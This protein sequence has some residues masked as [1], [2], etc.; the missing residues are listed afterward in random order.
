MAMLCTS[1]HFFVKCRTI[2]IHKALSMR[3]WPLLRNLHTSIQLRITP[4][5]KLTIPQWSHST[6]SETL[7]AL[8]RR[9]VTELGPCL[10]PTW[11]KRYFRLLC[12]C[13]GL[14]GTYYSHVP[15]GCSVWPVSLFCQSSTIIYTVTSGMVE[16]SS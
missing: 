9:K 2:I 14:P 3:P 13:R 1:A 16:S 10:S 4:S 12:G 7:Y 15:F 8:L 6:T 5:S 11:C